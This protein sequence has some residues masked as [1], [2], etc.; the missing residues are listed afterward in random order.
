MNLLTWNRALPPTAT[1][2]EGDLK[3]TAAT[4]STNHCSEIFD[5]SILAYS[6]VNRK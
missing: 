4:E 6:F 3:S 1:M 2:A 5:L